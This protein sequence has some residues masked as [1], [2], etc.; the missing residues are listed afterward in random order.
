MDDQ[1][2]IRFIKIE[3]YSFPTGLQLLQGWQAGDNESKK[4]MIQIL[5]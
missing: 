5:V 4:E 1:T 3:N 2:D